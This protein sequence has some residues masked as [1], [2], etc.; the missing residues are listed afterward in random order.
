[1]NIC[2][3]CQTSLTQADFD[4]GRCPTCRHLLVSAAE[5]DPRTAATIEVPAP[6]SPTSQQDHSTADD[7]RIAQTMAAAGIAPSTE[8][9]AP[10]GGPPDAAPEPGATDK[11]RLD[12]TIAPLDTARAPAAAPLT[13]ADFHRIAATIEGGKLPPDLI[14]NVTM[15][16]SGKLDT[17]VTPQNVR[18]S[19]ENLSI[20]EDTRRVIPSR[21]ISQA[22]AKGAAEPPSGNTADYELLSMLGEGGMGVVMSARQSSI[23][24]VVAVKK[25][26]P[27]EA[28]KV[29]SRQKFLAE[30]IVTGEL[31][32]PNIVPV[33]DLGK[34]ESGTLF[35]SMKHVKG[36]PWNRV[37]AKR[38]SRRTSKSG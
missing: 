4:R 18:S 31:E 34:D 29:E 20:D 28:V 7:E 5:N 27:S 30:A 38:A 15:F 12:A 2:D 33:Y 16:W 3:V 36:T 35:Y 8:T 23:D 37:I 9:G 21:A 26:K 14:K 22:K 10:A 19:L 11:H 25:I 1:M 13:E 17:R 32:H 6:D 24:R